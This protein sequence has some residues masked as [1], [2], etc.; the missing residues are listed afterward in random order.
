MSGG[1]DAYGVLYGHTQS[2]VLCLLL[3]DALVLC[4]QRD[5]NIS[6]VVMCIL[7]SVKKCYFHYL[8]LTIMLYFRFC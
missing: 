8:F 1:T 3:T 7:S 4:A 2:A 5:R 6:V